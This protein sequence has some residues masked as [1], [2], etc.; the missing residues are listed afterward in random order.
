MA[1]QSVYTCRGNRAE[2][3]YAVW[4]Q[5]HLVAMPKVRTLWI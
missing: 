3:V 1:L 5:M 2:A 4:M